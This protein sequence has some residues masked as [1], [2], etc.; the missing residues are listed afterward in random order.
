[1]YFNVKL[2]AVYLRSSPE[3]V[4]ERVKARGRPEEAGLSLQYLKDLHESHERWLMTYDERF[5]TIPVL[6]LDA[7]KTLDE[8]VEQYKKNENKI[9]GESRIYLME[10]NS[11]ICV[12]M[13][14][15][16]NMKELLDVDMNSLVLRLDFFS[17]HKI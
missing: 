16:V 6:V 11:N 4:Y 8:I 3:V 1:M 12:S 9:L 14:S 5:N 10:Q 17:L 2:F 15:K 7:D 13:I